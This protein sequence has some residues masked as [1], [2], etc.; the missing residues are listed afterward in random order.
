MC[1]FCSQQYINCAAYV[2]T[3]NTAHAVS[4]IRHGKPGAS[5]RRLR[6]AAE[7][8]RLGTGAHLAATAALRPPL[9][10]GPL[11]CPLRR[12]HKVCAAGS[13]CTRASASC[14]APRLLLSGRRAVL[15]PPKALFFCTRAELNA[16]E[17]LSESIRPALRVNVLVRP[18]FIIIHKNQSKPLTDIALCLK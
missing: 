5:L 10:G 1:F 18:K 17:E 7:P 3:R 14:T 16:A 8:L 6:C 12:V 9:P 13:R 15:S 2:M 11:T 4:S